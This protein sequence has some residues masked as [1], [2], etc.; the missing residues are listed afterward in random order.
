MALKRSWELVLHPDQQEAERG[1]HW[2]SLEYLKP[3]SPPVTH[4]FQLPTSPHFFQQGHTYFIK[5]IPPNA[6]PQT[7]KPSNRLA[8]GVEDIFFQPTIDCVLGRSVGRPCSLLLTVEDQNMSADALWYK[9]TKMLADI[10]ECHEPVSCIQVPCMALLMLI[11]VCDLY[12]ILLYWYI[13][14]GTPLSLKYAS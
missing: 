7:T 10:L 2:A 9:N 4:F 11:P 13:Q 1:K 14:S 12:I 5:A 3:Q 8:N 6:N